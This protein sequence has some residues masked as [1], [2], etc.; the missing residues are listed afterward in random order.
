MSEQDYDRDRLYKKKNSA[1]RFRLVRLNIMDIH[2]KRR[3]QK[4]TSVNR[5]VEVLV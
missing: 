1:H 4:Y 3:Y 2:M 5:A